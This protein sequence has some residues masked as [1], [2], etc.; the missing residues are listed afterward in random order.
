MIV[1]ES[2]STQK[3]L[4]AAFKQI[5]KEHDIHLESV[6]FET[7]QLPRGIGEE[8]VKREVVAITWKATSA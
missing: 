7:R 5:E 2:N 8:R 3:I 1:G 6:E 4:E